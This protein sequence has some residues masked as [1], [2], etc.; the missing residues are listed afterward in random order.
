MKII[1]FDTEVSVSLGTIQDYGAI[2]SLDATIHTSNASEFLNFIQDS[3]Y[4]CGH[5]VIHFDW[6][7]IKKCACLTEHRNNILEHKLIDTLY[8]SPLLFPQRPYHALLKDDKIISDELN[9][10][11]SDAKKARMLFLNE[12]EAFNN[13][14]D[15]LKRIFCALLSQQNEFRNFFQ[16][17][18]YYQV[19]TE[20]ESEIR[21]YF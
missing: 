7:Y 1:F 13:L 2:T 4:L 5:N 15:E 6:Q 16:Y 9:N 18:S 20:I 3:D 17:V 14:P 12:V 8:L 19:V 10:P 11:V 21:T